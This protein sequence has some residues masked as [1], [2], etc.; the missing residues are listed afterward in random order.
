MPKAHQKYLEWTPSRIP[1][2]AGKN[3]PNTRDPASC[4]M[5]NR[6]HPE[7]GF[8]SCLGIMRLLKR[9]SSERV[10]AACGRALFLKAYSFKSV[11][12]KLRQNHQQAYQCPCSG[13]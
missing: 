5:E 9:Y 11:E 6:K 8:R 10:E 1:D 2:W 7:Q 13:D 3:G 12:R 4:I